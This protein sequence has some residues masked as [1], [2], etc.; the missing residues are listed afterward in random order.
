MISLLAAYVLFSVMR[1][2][3]A[4][5]PVGLPEEG[6]VMKWWVAGGIFLA[7]CLGLALGADLLVDNVALVA[8]EIGISKRV[9]SIT[10]VGY[11]PTPP[12][13]T[14]SVETSSDCATS[15]SSEIWSLR[16]SVGKMEMF[17]TCWMMPRSETI[18]ASGVEE[19]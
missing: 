2:R 13:G 5:K 10:M 4:N 12:M 18:N 3:G 8:E 16:V 19:V 11:T 14:T 1:S 17:A 7:S 9:V 15:S 6:P